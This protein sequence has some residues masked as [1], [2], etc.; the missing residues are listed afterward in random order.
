MK[1][2][3]SLERGKIIENEWEENNKLNILI[4]DCINIENNLKDINIINESIPKYNKNININFLF[5]Y[6]TDN[7][8]QTIKNFGTLYKLDSLIIKRDKDINEFSKLIEN[9][10]K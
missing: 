9:D 2:K 5:K 7:L 1:I 10:N 4:N 8:I 3:S 6:D